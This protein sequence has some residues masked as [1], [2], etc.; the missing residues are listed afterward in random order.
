VSSRQ[1]SLALETTHAPVA[2]RP[3]LRTVAVTPEH[4]RADV[5]RSFERDRLRLY[6]VRDWI[7]ILPLPLAALDAGAPL[8]VA[9][10]AALRGVVNAFGIL[11][12]G[13]LL[14]AVSDRHVD[15][16]PRKNPLI[17]PDAPSYRSS[18]IVLPLVGLAMAA[19]SP[20][21]VQL[22][23]LWCLLLGCLYSTGPRLKSLPV[24]GS[25]INAAGFTPILF[26]GMASVSLPPRFAYVAVAFAGLLFQNQLIHEAADRIED[27]ASGI[28]TTWLTLGPR[29][30]AL[31]A[32]MAGCL[33]TAATVSLLARGHWLVFSAVVAA[34]FVVGFPYRLAD[35]R[36]G[37]DEA[38]R[39]RLHH[40]WCCALVGAALY[41]AWRLGA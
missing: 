21:P 26:L 29:W 30:T 16:D 10:G 11:A 3:P 19:F 35:P 24:A 23:T 15:R 17:E 18:L 39:I 4:A 1:R 28:R 25:I 31:F 33:A 9:L 37:P 22:A 38:G 14:N 36:L 20:R 34:M 32:C 2:P 40:R 41:A 7:H 8:D 13:F 5:R 12:F 27:E 6:R